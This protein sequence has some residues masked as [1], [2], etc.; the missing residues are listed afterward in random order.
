MFV[1]FQLHYGP[2]FDQPLTEVVPEIFLG[3][4]SNQHIRLTTSPPAIRGYP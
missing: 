1:D 4:K 3:V 2:G